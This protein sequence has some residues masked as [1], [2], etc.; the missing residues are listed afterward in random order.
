MFDKQWDKNHSTNDT[1]YVRE[2][3]KTDHTQRERGQGSETT[4][5]RCSAHLLPIGEK[6]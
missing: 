5:L 6:R 1:E 2:T 3:S 4:L